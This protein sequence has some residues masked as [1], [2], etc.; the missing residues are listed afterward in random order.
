MSIKTILCYVKF[1]FKQSLS[2]EEHQHITDFFL[3]FP[4][5]GR[6]KKQKTSLT[7]II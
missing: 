2:V 5:K 3:F 7:L 4:Q 6:P 1:S